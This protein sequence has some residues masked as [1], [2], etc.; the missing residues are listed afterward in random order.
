MI[1]NAHDNSG[2]SDHWVKK[3]PCRRKRQLVPISCLE[4]SM[5]RGACWTI[6]SMGL[7]R[8]GHN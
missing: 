7:Q 3:I 4:N 8:L 1:K 2:D 6:Q 5:D